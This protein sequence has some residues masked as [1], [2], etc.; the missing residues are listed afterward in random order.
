MT[1]FATTGRT[2]LIDPA[3]MEQIAHVCDALAVD[4]LCQALRRE[5]E[6]AASVPREFM[7]TVRFSYRIGQDR[8]TAVPMASN[9]T[10]FL[11]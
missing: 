11:P 7:T 4:G 10:A 8:R 1:K 5:Q 2:D 6:C 3:M 9:I